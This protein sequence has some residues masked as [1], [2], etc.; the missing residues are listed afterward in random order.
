[1]LKSKSGWDYHGNELNGSF[2]TPRVYK[3]GGVD[4]YGFGVIS[5]GTRGEKASFWST[6]EHDEENSYYLELFSHAVW[7]CNRIG[8]VYG[9]KNKKRS[10]RCVKD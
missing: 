5:D 7:N 9:Q 3:N 1:M 2:V 10:V 4:Y 8:V 6:L